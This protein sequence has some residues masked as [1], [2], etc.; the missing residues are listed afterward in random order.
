MLPRL[1]CCCFTA[2]RAEGRHSHVLAALLSLLPL[3]P[4]SLLPLLHLC[5]VIQASWQNT[6]C[7][8][9]LLVHVVLFLYSYLPCPVARF[10]L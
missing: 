6:S 7:N 5:L 8:T 4:A 1:L 10:A 2:A 9:Q 3:Q